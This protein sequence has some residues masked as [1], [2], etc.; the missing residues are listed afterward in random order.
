MKFVADFYT[1]F[2]RTLDDVAVVEEVESGNALA[3]NVQLNYYAVGTSSERVNFAGFVFIVGFDA[4]EAAVVPASSLSVN[5]VLKSP[6]I[7][8]NRFTVRVSIK[9]GC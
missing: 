8:S 1:N 6:N 7:K 4:A 3:A 9:K 2:F 5:A